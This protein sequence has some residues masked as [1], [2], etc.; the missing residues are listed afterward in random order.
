[1]LSLN[2][3]R[4]PLHADDVPKPL[5]LNELLFGSIIQL[6]KNK[7]TNF[8]EGTLF[9]IS[10]SIPITLS[11]GEKTKARGLRNQSNHVKSEQSGLMNLKMRGPHY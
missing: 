8:P 6:K 5:E 10:T 1:L 9:V 4:P 2:T 11:F 7:Q 3:Q